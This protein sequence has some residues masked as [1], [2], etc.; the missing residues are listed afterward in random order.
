MLDP[1][2]KRAPFEAEAFQDV[3]DRP[4]IEQCHRHL[5][6]EL[7]IEYI[8]PS[9]APVSPIKRS[10]GN[11]R[12]TFNLADPN[13]LGPIA[14]SETAQSARVE[15]NKY[16]AESR[17]PPTMCPLLWWKQNESSFPHLARMAR[18]F[19]TIPGII[20]IDHIL[21][22]YSPSILLQVHRHVLNA[23]LILAAM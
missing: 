13:L 11:S 14:S 23:H 20:S 6:S 10:N 18:T 3:F 4:W 2:Y 22:P 7:E 16:L 17:I 1:R 15:L 19:L 21:F 9:P 8:S 5:L 12:N